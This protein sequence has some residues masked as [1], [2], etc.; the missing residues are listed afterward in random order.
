[1]NEVITAILNSAIEGS[2]SVFPFPLTTQKPSLVK[3]SFPMNA[4]AVLIGVTGDLRGRFLLVAEDSVFASVAESMYGMTLSGEMLNSFVGEIGN[5]VAGTMATKL[6]LRKFRV[7]ITPPTVLSGSTTIS[8]FKSA[9]QV[10]VD[11]GERGQLTLLLIF[12]E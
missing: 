4:T 1:M 9:I 3:T 10:P 6:S 12:E 8:G 7:D 5:I 11:A 2:A